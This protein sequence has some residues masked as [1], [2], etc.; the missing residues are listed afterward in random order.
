[1]HSMSSISARWTSI[2]RPARWSEPTGQAGAPSGKSA[3]SALIRW[4][5][6]RSASSSSQ[7]RVMAVSTRPLS[8]MGSAMITS[9]AEIRSEATISRR[10]SPAS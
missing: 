8:G 1:M 4:L 9:K 2:D 3:G 7:C 10:P 5:G 6:A